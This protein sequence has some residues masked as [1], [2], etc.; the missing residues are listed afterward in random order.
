MA[1]LRRI[2]IPE[3]A[4]VLSAWGM[5]ASDLRYEISRTHIGDHAVMDDASLRSIFAEL[6]DS[7][8]ARLQSWFDGRIGIERSA[9]MRYG[10]QIFEIDVPLD[11]LDWDARGLIGR[12]HEAFH[13]RHEDLYT[14]AA[15]DQEVVFINAR[16]AAVGAIHTAEQ[17]T[18]SAAAQT[19]A[20]PQ[21]QRMAFFGVRQDTPVYDIAALAPG[22]SLTGP[23]IL[24]AETTTVIVNNGDR[25]S[26]NALAWLDIQ[27]APFKTR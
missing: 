18:K 14:Y 6:E 23:A 2:Y 7:A 12:V 3:L 13:Q 20:R 17:P 26:V 19:N 21:T 25:V 11:H 15:R 10:E 24:E 8:T 16:V 4:S 1:G 22:A 5:L 27:L 9:E